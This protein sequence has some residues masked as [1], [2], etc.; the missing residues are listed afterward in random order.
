MDTTS[1][2]QE[3]CKNYNTFYYQVGGKYP[4]SSSTLLNEAKIF[5]QKKNDRYSGSGYITFRFTID[6]DGKI[7]KQV[8]VLQTDESY[9]TYHFNKSLVNELYS[10]LKTLDKWKIAKT[11]K[12]ESVSYFAFLTFKIQNGKIINIIP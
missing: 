4:K 8:Q 7:M 10:Y 3:N 1:A 12:G 2:P 9:Q 11:A 5:L 6:C